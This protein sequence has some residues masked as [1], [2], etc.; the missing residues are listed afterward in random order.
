[1]STPRIDVLRRA[2]DAQFKA[3]A[4]AE[5][6]LAEL[7]AVNLSTLQEWLEELRPA[8]PADGRKEG[9]PHGE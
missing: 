2:L 3:I 9:T 1:V 4:K 6:D 5:R 7:K 8:A